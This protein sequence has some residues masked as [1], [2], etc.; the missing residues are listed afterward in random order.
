LRQNK[1]LLE[2][3]VKL[4]DIRDSQVSRDLQE[5]QYRAAEMEEKRRQAFTIMEKLSPAS[6][7]SDQW[8]RSIRWKGCPEFGD[9]FLDHELMKNWLKAPKNESVLW[10]KGSPG[11]GEFRLSREAQSLMIEQAKRS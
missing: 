8:R 6:S 5:H 4:L 11:A 7:D 1:N 2:S 9:W 3:A 10:L